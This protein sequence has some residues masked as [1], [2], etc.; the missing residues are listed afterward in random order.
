[1]SPDTTEPTDATKAE[2][3]KDARS[4]HDPGDMPTAEEEQAA[5]SNEPVDPDVAAAA[6]EQHKTGA[7]VEGE[8]AI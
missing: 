5:E 3:A 2:D 8:G 4:S 7:E 6:K 1:M